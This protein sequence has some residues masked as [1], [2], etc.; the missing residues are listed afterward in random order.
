MGSGS[1]V[2]RLLLHAR[3]CF[4]PGTRQDGRLVNHSK[5]LIWKSRVDWYYSVANSRI[6]ET[7]AL[8]LYS[9]WW[10]QPLWKILV[11]MGI[12]P[13]YGWKQK[14]F[15][16]TTLSCWKFLGFSSKN[17]FP[18]FRAAGIISQSCEEPSQRKV[19]SMWLNVKVD[20][21]TIMTS[22]NNPLSAWVSLK[23]CW[24][25]MSHATD[26]IKIQWLHQLRAG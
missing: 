6:L 3:S 23:N 7:Q 9:S 10:F 5:Y 25:T 11:K 17:H 15:E 20:S 21:I 1:I 13:R 24:G 8:G 4:K 16:T 18:Q 12:F 14:M 19:G 2:F 22:W 26:A